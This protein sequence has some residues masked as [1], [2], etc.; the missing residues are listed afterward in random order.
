MRD[1]E[2]RLVARMGKLEKAIVA[3]T[4]D[5][6]RKLI[7]FPAPV[8]KKPLKSARPVKPS[9][10]QMLAALLDQFNV[11]CQPM[12]DQM[13]DLLEFLG[14]DGGLLTRARKL[15]LPVQ[16]VGCHGGPEFPF[17]SLAVVKLAASNPKS[18]S[19]PLN[20]PM[21]VSDEGVGVFLF[22]GAWAVAEE[23]PTDLKAYRPVSAKELQD[24][25][26]NLDTLMLKVYQD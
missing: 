9:K 16:P 1:H 12:A 21:V 25:L 15:V 8:V 2:K 20:K 3:A 6:A 13:A 7:K 11:G 18:E 22:K 5:A 26:D 23:L 14:I 4:E 17:L 10:E 19:Y 24:V